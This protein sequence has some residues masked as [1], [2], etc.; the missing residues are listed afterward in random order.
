MMYHSEYFW[1][2]NSWQKGNFF[3]IKELVRDSK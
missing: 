3:T 1:T 2:I